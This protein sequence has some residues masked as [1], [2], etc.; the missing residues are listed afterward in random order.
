MNILSLFAHC[1]VI[2]NLFDFF[3]FVEQK[4][5]YFEVFIVGNNKLVTVDFQCMG[6][7]YKNIFFFVSHK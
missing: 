5:R 7:N 6:K 2:P 4:R 1:N 3:A